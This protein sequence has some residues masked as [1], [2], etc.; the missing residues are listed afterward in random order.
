MKFLIFFS[1]ITRTRRRTLLK[2]EQSISRATA[3]FMGV[4]QF[5]SPKSRSK[6]LLFNRSKLQ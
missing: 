6:P 5:S 2:K 4:N 3:K 1:I